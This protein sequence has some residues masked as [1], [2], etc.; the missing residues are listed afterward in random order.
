MTWDADAAKDARDWHVNQ[1]TPQ[2]IGYTLMDDTAAA[3][4]GKG[5]FAI[6]TSS[7][8]ADNQNKWI[9]N[10]KARLKEKYPDIHLIT[11]RPC[12]D[13]QRKAFD[14]TTTILAAN[15]NI[16]AIMAVCSPGVPG[17][18]EAVEQAKR[19][20]VKVVGLGLPNENKNTSTTASPPAS[21]C[22]TRRTWATSRFTPPKPRSMARSSPAPPASRPDALAPSKSRRT[23]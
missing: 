12:D 3:L 8:T 7:L 13:Q 18:A 1:G 21:S 4:G 11:I 16:K 22:G 19:S 20:D 2:A 14:E 10:V 9:E 5:D 6:I 23:M 15:P 17:A